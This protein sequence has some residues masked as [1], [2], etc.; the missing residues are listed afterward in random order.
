MN[1]VVPR[2]RAA[3]TKPGPSCF[4]AAVHLRPVLLALCLAAG[5]APAQPHV[6]GASVDELLAIARERTPELAA[7]RLEAEAVAERVVP[8]AAFP[9]PMARVELQ[10]IDNDGRGFPTLLPSRV[11]STKYTLVQ[12]LPWFGKRDLRR[13]GAEADAEAAR[14][15]VD[16]AWAEVAMR[17]KTAYAQ[18]WQVA[19]TERLVRDVLDLMARLEE[20]AQ[21]RY[22]GGLAAQ[23]DAIRAQTERTAMEG[24][25]IMLAGDRRR[26]IASLNAVLV[27]PATA[28]L[29][30]PERIRALPAGA[31]LDIALLTDRLVARN[32]A[33]AVEA[34]RITSAERARDLAYRNR[35]PDVSIGVSPIQVGSRIAE[36]ELMLEVTI[37]LQQ[38]VKRSQEREAERMHDAALA[39]KATAFVR[40]Q[41]E[42]GGAVAA[43]ETARQTEEL[44]AGRLLPLARINFESALAGYENGK[45]DFAAL[46]EAQRQIRKARQDIVKAQAEQQMRLAELERIVGE[47][48]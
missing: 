5:P 26:A 42:L 15:R 6:P 7:M 19:H 24:E 34:A 39:R 20:I 40:L 35:F 22:A 4:A 48:L 23:Q 12:S 18:Y 27:R 16:D 32:P 30:E 36:W 41:G 37:P 13:S 14:L 45:I 9:D 29:A 17:V 44:I 46:L 31:V 43:L 38:N 2:L 28:A 3:G 47:D 21:A 10:D 25:L 1:V 8:A 33:L 11:G